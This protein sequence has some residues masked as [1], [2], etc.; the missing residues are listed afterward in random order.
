MQGDDDA[1]NDD[2]RTSESGRERVV[3]R[4]FCVVLVVVVVR[5]LRV[6]CASGKDMQ[7]FERKRERERKEERVV[8]RPLLPAACCRE[9]NFEWK[10]P[11][12]RPS[13]AALSE[14]MRVA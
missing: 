4:C 13:R 5:R 1:F 9:L 10:N 7:T 8:E 6:V 3:K 14:E 12:R 2:A 11:R